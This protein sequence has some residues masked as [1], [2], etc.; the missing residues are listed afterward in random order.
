MCENIRG[1]ENRDTTREDNE[2]GDHGS[3]NIYEQVSGWKL[4]LKRKITKFLQDN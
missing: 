2:R 3:G 4:T 1:V